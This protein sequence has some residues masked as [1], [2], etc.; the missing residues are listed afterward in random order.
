M[1]PA[2]RRTSQRIPIEIPIHI[3]EEELVTCDVS[4]AGIYFQSDHLFAEGGD[5]NFSLDL[6]YASPG[7][8]IEFVCQGVVVRV[9]QHDGKFGI[10]AKI[11]NLQLIH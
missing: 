2:E 1:N 9:E 3:G 6:A 4:R 10:A 11:T 7:E 5:L 8:S